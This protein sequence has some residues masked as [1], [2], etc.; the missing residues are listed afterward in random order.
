[1]NHFH[2]RFSPSLLLAIGAVLYILII[3]FTAPVNV[4]DT[5]SY[6]DSIYRT[7][8]HNPI[9]PFHPLAEFGH[10]LWRPLGYVLNPLFQ[11]LAPSSL[12]PTA[13]VKTA[14]GLVWLSIFAGLVSTLLVVRILD[15]WANSPWWLTLIGTAAFCSGAGFQLYSQAGT[16]YITTLMFALLAV[17]VLL[18]WPP[19]S[20]IPVEV[21]ACLVLLAGVLF[22][23]PFILMAPAVALF[24][25]WRQGR[26]RWSAIAS[27]AGVFTLLLVM[28]YVTAA[29]M[30]GVTSLAQFKLWYADAQHAMGQNRQALRAVSGMSRLLYQLADDGVLMKRFLFHDPYAPVGVS[31]LVP[32]ALRLAGFYGL[33]ALAL[34]ATWFQKERRYLVPAFLTAALPMIF[35][36]I[37]LF[38]PSSPERF[39]PVLP[40]LLLLWGAAAGSPQR[41]VRYALAGLLLVIPFSNLPQVMAS[42]A[43]PAAARMAGFRQVAQ[44]GDYLVTVTFRDPMVNLIEQHPFHPLNQPQVPKTYQ[45]IEIASAGAK[46]WRRSFARLALATWPKQQIWV[47]RAVQSPTPAAYLSWVESDNP[48]IQ[49]KQVPEFFAPLQLDAPSGDRNAGFLL[50]SPSIA[51]QNLLKNFAE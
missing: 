12:A 42:E 26:L 37:F 23:F 5:P 34:G 47:D 9:G 1:M 51:N 20:A 17:V 50:L 18:E 11:S 3:V 29:W 30:A 49:W 39:F 31:Q 24:P 32:I 6:V 22:W 41:W 25:S 2:Q 15:R 10:L 40:F 33:C 4:G 16:S 7:L 27:A 48:A 19:A 21:P 8:N 13:Q 44:P 46:D 36:A 28:V 35:F 38:E 14:L 43:H 45:L